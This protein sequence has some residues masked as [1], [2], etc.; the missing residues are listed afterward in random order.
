MMFSYKT[1]WGRGNIL[2]VTWLL[3]RGIF[4]AFLQSVWYVVTYIWRKKHLTC[5]FFYKCECELFDYFTHWLYDLRVILNIIKIIFT[6]LLFLNDICL[7]RSYFWENKQ[8]WIHS[9]AFSMD[10]NKI[11]QLG[12]IFLMI[13]FLLPQRTYF[14][15]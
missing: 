4:F 15:V 1:A 9:F 6:T 2:V 8:S 12:F 3:R 14:N 11:D 5:T 13:F 7:K 10:L